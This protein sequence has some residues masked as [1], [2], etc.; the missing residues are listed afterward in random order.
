MNNLRLRWNALFG[1]PR[2]DFAQYPAR[3]KTSVILQTARNGNQ[4][5]V[6]RPI[7]PE[8]EPAMGRFHPP[9]SQKAVCERYFE[10]FTLDGRIDHRRLSQI[11]T[12]NP[13]SFALGVECPKDLGQPVKILAVRRLTTMDEPCIAAFAILTRDDARNHGFDAI[14]LRR[15]IVRARASGSGSK[16]LADDNMVLNHDLLNLCKKLGF[17]LHAIQDKGIVHV[18]L[19]L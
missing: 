19:S 9:L 8:D 16:L 10:H 11:C 3:L 12:N 18:C 13:D 15:L 1:A 7:R 5:Q 14:M 2:F 17:T 4:S 6:L